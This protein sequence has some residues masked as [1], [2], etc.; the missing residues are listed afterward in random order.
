MGIDDLTL[1]RSGGCAA[2]RLCVS[3]QSTTV[4]VIRGRI[5]F[6]NSVTIAAKGKYD[7]VGWQICT[8][9]RRCAASTRTAGWSAKSAKLSTVREILPAAAR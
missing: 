7:G 4:M 2:R 1:N 9:S 8:T 3:V 6:G 5:D